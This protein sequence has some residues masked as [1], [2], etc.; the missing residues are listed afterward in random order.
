MNTAACAP[1]SDPLEH[2]LLTTAGLVAEAHAGMSRVLERRLAADAQLSV[3][4]FEVLV[5]LVRTPGHRLRM[6]DLA[7]QT[8]L[9]PS[10]LTRAVD[11]LE[12]A[13]LVR[14]VPC[15]TDRRSAWATLTPEGEAR[16]NRAVPI[17]VAHLTEL[18]TPI[19]GPEQLATFSDLVR[20]LRDAV[21]PT[22]V[23]ASPPRDEPV[24]A[25]P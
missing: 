21:H 3:Q 7:A 17:H 23:Q 19:F 12:V 1:V 20:Q 2:P 24:G 13:G 14:R 15:E 18:L 10:G 9:S 8:T 16:I 25:A 11:R 4:W 5:R 6:S 22:A